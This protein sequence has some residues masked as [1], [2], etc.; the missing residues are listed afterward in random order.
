MPDPNTNEPNPEPKPNDP[1]Q[2]GD[3]KPEGPQTYEIKVNGEARQVTLEEMTKLAEKAGGADAKFQEA[4]KL[5]KEAQ[6][7]IRIDGLLGRMRD[8]EYEPDDADITELATMIGVS[9]EEF[10]AQLKADGGDKGGAGDKNAQAPSVDFEKELQERFGRS[11]AEVKSILEMAYNRE[12]EGARSQIRSETDKDVDKDEFF[13]KM[14]IGKDGESRAAAIRE[15]VAED[16]FR[17]IASGEPYGP[18]LRAAS[19]QKVRAHL[20]SFGIPGNPDQDPITMGLGP[21]VGL[22]AEV[23]SE[24]PIKRMSAADDKDGENFV[25]RYMQKGLQML[26]NKARE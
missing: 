1:P 16:V 17:R 15:M 7:G 4:S 10:M 2:S 8:A 19:I 11:P 5:H 6:R 22:P 25:Q 23:R 3:P 24:T 13:G 18:E 26:R 14:K 12:I 21:S 9:P 20:K